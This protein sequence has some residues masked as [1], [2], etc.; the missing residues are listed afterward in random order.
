M[1][2]YNL[3]GLGATRTCGELTQFIEQERERLCQHNLRMSWREWGYEV[4]YG[5]T[6]PDAHAIEWGL[7]LIAAADRWDKMAQ[8][9]DA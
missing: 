6:D 4:L 9:E 8:F 3:E 2:G 1:A 5:P 7:L